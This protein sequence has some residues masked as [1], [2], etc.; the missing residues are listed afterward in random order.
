MTIRVKCTTLFDITATGVKNR[1]HK[2]RLPFNDNTGKMVASDYE[3]Q[4]SRNQQCN[5]ETVNQVISLRTLPENITTPR[6]VDN[7]WTFE[8]NVVDP[9]TIFRDGDPVAAL[10]DDC[11]GV[12][13]VLGLSEN[14]E[15]DPVLAPGTNIWFELV[16][17]E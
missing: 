4:R 11:I 15:L 7:R 10:K 8:F 3:W 5:W 17:P 13:M 2:S 16:V 14:G 6:A 1:F 9:D 12:P